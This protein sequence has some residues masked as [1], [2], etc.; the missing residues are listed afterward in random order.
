M[1]A[2]IETGR[3]LIEVKKQLRHGEWE[4]L[5]SGHENAVRRPL[6]FTVRKAQRLMAIAAHPVISKTTHASS[7]PASWDTLYQLTKLPGTALR[8]ALTDGRVHPDMERRDVAAL[9]PS[10][11]SPKI[12]EAEATRTTVTATGLV[13]LHHS[14]AENLDAGPGRCP[15]ITEALY[16]D[17]LARV[18]RGELT[19]RDF[20][21][22]LCELV[23][24]ARGRTP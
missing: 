6:P 2:A 22:E 15:S 24:R 3:A 23:A 13:G 4:R 19:F 14:H 20:A 8:K 17:Y 11:P 5:F 21:H 16:L 18:N 7:L 10:K 12:I 9:R 1:R